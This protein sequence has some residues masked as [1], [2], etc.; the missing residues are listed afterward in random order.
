MTRQRNP[1]HEPSGSRRSARTVHRGAELETAANVAFARNSLRSP[2]P[3]LD[4]TRLD[5]R[6]HTRTQVTRYCRVCRR[7]RINLSASNRSVSQKPPSPPRCVRARS[8]SELKIDRMGAA[9][10][11]AQKGANLRHSRNPPLFH[12]SRFTYATLDAGSTAGSAPSPS[13]SDRP[14]VACAGP[15]T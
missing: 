4:P 9:R 3:D 7:C 8:P 6:R 15:P 14:D 5:N 1:R 10:W 12:R 13:V 2:M 11:M